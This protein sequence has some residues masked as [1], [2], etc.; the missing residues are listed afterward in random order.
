M[1]AGGLRLHCTVS[2]SKRYSAPHYSLCTRAK[3]RRIHVWTS[4][5]AVRTCGRLDAWPYRPAQGLRERQLNLLRRTPTWDLNT[6]THV[7]FSLCVFSFAHTHP[8]S[9][10]LSLSLALPKKQAA[11]ARG[12]CLGKGLAN[13]FAATA[14][15]HSRHAASLCTAPVLLT[16]TRTHPLACYCRHVGAQFNPKIYEDVATQGC[17]TVDSATGAPCARCVC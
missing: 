2:R 15:M 4:S 13:G 7:E 11:V 5:K 12:A 3:D 14:M 8:H 6:H 10:A 1:A 16:V 9:L 17:V